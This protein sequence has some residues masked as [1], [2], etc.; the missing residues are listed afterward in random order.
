[1]EVRSVI[2]ST[3]HRPRPGFELERCKNGTSVWLK[4]TRL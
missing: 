4:V 2:D 3:S 1:M